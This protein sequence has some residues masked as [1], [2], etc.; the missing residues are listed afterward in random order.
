MRLNVGGGMPGHRNGL[1][2]DLDDFFH[3]IGAAA[4]AFA[5]PPALLCEPGRAMVSEAMTLALRVRAR[6]GRQVFLNDGLYGSLAE[7]ADI[8][9]VDR[10]T[11]LTDKPGAM[12]PFEAFGPTCDSLDRL[13]APLM[14]PD[15]IAEGDYVLFAG[16]G[17]YSSALATRFNGFGAVDVVPVARL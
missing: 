6:C 4:Q 2:H 17:A 3:V 5:V 1:A 16:M 7:F 10:V 12:L 11:V 15:T 14:L 8:G 9:P 13:N